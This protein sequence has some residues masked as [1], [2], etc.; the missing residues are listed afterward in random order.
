VPVTPAR[1]IIVI[2]EW[3]RQWLLIKQ[4]CSM[5]IKRIVLIFFMILILSSCLWGKYVEKSY[6][7][8]DFGI[9]GVGVG[10]IRI[11][12]IVSDNTRYLIY[13]GSGCIRERL[14]YRLL[15]SPYTARFEFINSNEIEKIIIENIILETNGKEESLLRNIKEIIFWDR[16][17]K[18]IDYEIEPKK[19]DEF[20][21]TQTVEFDNPAT[22]ISIRLKDINIPYA[23]V[24]N[25]IL[26]FNM[27]VYL[28]DGQIHTV[29]K[30]YR[31]T[32]F[33]SSHYGSYM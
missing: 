22:T 25:I 12:D 24:E 29:D 23:K 17:D 30:E 27:I 28:K 16:G 15:G 11:R 21:I 8:I 9:D 7:F 14:F 26:K 20:Y 18:Y 5:P 1:P 3:M 33:K 32:R 13:F 2:R 31:L 19:I 4:E 10:G 6:A